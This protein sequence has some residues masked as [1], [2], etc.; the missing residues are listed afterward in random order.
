MAG[1]R[2]TGTLLNAL[3]LLNLTYVGRMSAE[4]VQYGEESGG[5]CTPTQQRSILEAVTGC[6]AR[7]TLLA[8]REHMPNV[9]D[10]I[11]VIPDFASVARCG[12]SCDL[13]K[14][15]CIPTETRM[16]RVDVMV[17]LSRFPRVQTETQCGYVEVEEHVGC[18]CD[19]PVKSR[20]CRPDDQYYEGSSCR[21]IC[22]DQA[23][24]NEC[25][26]SGMLWD[27]VNCLCVCPKASWRV[28]STGYIFDFTRT[29]QCVPTSTTAS[30]GLLVAVIVLVTCLLVS[31]AGGF[32]MYRRQ[33][34]L[35]KEAAKTRRRNTAV[36]GA[37]VAKHLTEYDLVKEEENTS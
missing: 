33:T 13:Y 6:E 24:R 7:E 10:V 14:H 19:C 4:A 35:F 20:H 22:L 17:V 5:S 3:L 18:R 8:L 11:Q 16:K 36:A 9:S 23:R 2:D 1:R 31:V 30:M 28:C 27:P 26:I 37:D 15:R 32:F 12:G 25:I 21:C 34:G 29:C